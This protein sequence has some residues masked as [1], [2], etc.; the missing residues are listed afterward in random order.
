VPSSI[1]IDDENLASDL[2][3]IAAK[4]SVFSISPK[5]AITAASRIRTLAKLLQEADRQR[6]QAVSNQA[7]RYF[8]A[9]DAA[10]RRSI[11]GVEIETMSSSESYR[12]RFGETVPHSE[13]EGVDA[14][15]LFGELVSEFARQLAAKLGIDA[16]FDFDEGAGDLTVSGIV[17]TRS[18][19]MAM[20]MASYG[21]SVTPVVDTAPVRIVPSGVHYLPEEETE[22]SD[23]DDGDDYEER[24]E[25]DSDPFCTCMVCTR[26]RAMEEDAAA[27]DPVTEEEAAWA[28]RQADIAAMRAAIRDI[29]S[30]SSWQPYPWTPVG[31]QYAEPESERAIS[32]SDE[33]HWRRTRG[34]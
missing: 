25:D 23:G 9:P 3:K 26:A 33:N 30:P 17:S 12:V 8:Q 31:P 1:G 10:P 27:A 21:Y 24:D 15:V 14:S 5:P 6:D 32:E 2:D 13:L 7:S 18:A 11:R 22:P 16:E 20:S 4:L 19:A 29:P 34:V 28:R